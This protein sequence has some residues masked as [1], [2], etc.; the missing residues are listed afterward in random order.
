MARIRD[1][2]L[3]DA[4]RILEIYSY[5]VE[6]T[7]ITFEYVTPSIEEFRGRMTN[8]MQKYPYLVIEDEDGVIQGYSYAGPLKGRAA[9][10]WSAEMTVYLAAD[11]L[12][13]GYGKQIYDAMEEALQ[14]MGIL[15]LYACIGYPREE[16][17]FLQSNSEVFHAHIGYKLIGVFHEC[18]YKFGTWY[19]MIWM[20]KIIGEHSKK[21][22]PITPYPAIAKAE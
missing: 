14:N 3:G 13:R 9:Y 4:E 16:D 2:V 17:Q 10:D 18:G 8:T 19:D 5:Y 11:V 12:R 6:N 7:A 20:E 1:A 22:Q 15:N 21:M